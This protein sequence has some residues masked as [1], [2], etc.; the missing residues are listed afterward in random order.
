MTQRISA[1]NLNMVIKRINSAMGS[2]QEPYTKDAD[3]KYHANVG[4]FHLSQAYGGYSLHRMEN[5]SGGA[6]DV[7][8]CGHTS[9]RSLYEQMF[10][11]IKGMELNESKGAK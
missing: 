4:N 7:L 5:A 10:A 6:S 1:A 3:G 8:S 2:P 11:L 9:A